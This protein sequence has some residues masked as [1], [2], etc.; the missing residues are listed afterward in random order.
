MQANHSIDGVLHIAAL[1]LDDE[2]ELDLNHPPIPK[3]WGEFK[4][5]LR[6]R[7]KEGRERLTPYK[8]ELDIKTDGRSR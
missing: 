5:H 2:R 4:E 6:R 1:T 7:H 3:T 8:T